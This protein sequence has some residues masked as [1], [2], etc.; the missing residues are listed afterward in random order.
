M[1][2]ELETRNGH[3]MYDIAS[4]LQKSIRRCDLEKASYAAY[5]LY[6]R[7]SQYLWRRMLVISAEDCYGIMT[8][9]IV[10]LYQ[11]DEFVNNGRKGYDKDAIFLAK[12][13]YLLCM[14]RKNRDACYVACNFM[15]PDR[16]MN[17]KAIPHLDLEELEKMQ[18]LPEWVYDIHTIKGKKMGKTDVE[19]TVNEQNALTPHQIGLFDDCSWKNAYEDDYYKGKLSSREWELY[20]KYLADKES[21]PSRDLIID[22]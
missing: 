9:E 14:A 3:N 6:G 16:I 7:F 15:I 2:Y 19:M 22:E 13:I 20:N 12:A 21:N 17:P 10:A 8:K 5:E 4:L 11:A 1:G 18:T